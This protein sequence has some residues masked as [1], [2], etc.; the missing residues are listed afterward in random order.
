MFVKGDRRMNGCIY[1]DM[2]PP[3]PCPIPL[4]VRPEGC[5]F[6]GINKEQKEEYIEM[7]LQRIEKE[8]K[9]VREYLR[10]LK[11]TEE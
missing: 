9:Y 4:S 3:K 5:P 11:E 10:Q 6:R 8:I 7:S 1:C 2:E